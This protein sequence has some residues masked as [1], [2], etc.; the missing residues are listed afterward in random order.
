MTKHSKRRLANE[1]SSCEWAGGFIENHLVCLPRKKGFWVRGV[2][3]KLPEFFES[4][5]DEFVAGDLRDPKVADLA[6]KGIGDAP[7]LAAGIDAPGTSLPASTTP[8]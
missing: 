6:V 8:V 7:P 5:A 1:K 3:L 4:S 2:D